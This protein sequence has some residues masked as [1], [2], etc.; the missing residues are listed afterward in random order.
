MSDILHPAPR[1]QF[2]LP[3][4][5]F[6]WAFILLSVPLWWILRESFGLEILDY[7]HDHS[8]Q[9]GA[10]NNLFGIKSLSDDVRRQADGE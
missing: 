4:F 6:V 2:N 7:G 5:D 8:G 1:A 10:A 9:V 3:K